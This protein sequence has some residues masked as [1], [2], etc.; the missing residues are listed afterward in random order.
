MKHKDL[1]LKDNRPKK[2][3][4]GKAG[5]PRK[6]INWE[7]FEELC[8]LQCPQSEI[9]SILKIHVDTLRDSA[10]AHYEEPDF[11]TIYK[12]FTE[13]GKCSLRRHQFVL[14]KTN[15]AMAIFLGKNL[16]GQSDQ[17]K[18]TQELIISELRRGIALISGEQRGEKPQLPGMAS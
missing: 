14:S 5:R 1:K 11:S 9:A 18:E 16:L 4:P 2:V 17:V 8:G 3:L 13:C 12:K 15:A 6:E 10:I 7:L